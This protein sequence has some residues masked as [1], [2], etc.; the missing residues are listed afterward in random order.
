MPITAADINK[1]FRTAKYFDGV[2]N[3]ASIYWNMLQRKVNVT[4]LANGKCTAEL[5][6]EEEHT[7]IMGGLHGG[8]SA[9][10]VDCIS[11]YAL[12][13]KTSLPHVSVQINTEYIKGAKL[14]D[15]IEIFGNT[16]KMGKSLAFLEVL[17][18]DKNTGALLVK[19][20]HTKFLLGPKE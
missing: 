3:K 7:N 17:I 16:V 4:A 2:L 9:T 20:S 11:S 14:G 12:V 15:Q 5:T 13:S 8:L 10:L 6:L 19:G 1:M 18:K